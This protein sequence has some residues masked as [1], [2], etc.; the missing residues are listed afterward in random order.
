VVTA[1]SELEGIIDRPTWRYAFLQHGV[2]KDDLS[3]WLNKKQADLF[4]V[5][6]D[7]ELESVAGD[8]TAYWYTRKETRN[9]G[10]PRFDRL[11]RKAAA[12]QPDARDIVLVAPTWRAWLTTNIDV[13][14]FERDIDSAFWDSDYRRN[15]DRVLR[16]PRIEAALA[17]AGLTLG[18]MPHPAMQPILGRLD[19]PPHVRPFTFVGEDVQAL[20]AR[21]ALLVTDYSSVAFNVAYIDGPIVYFQFDR[22]AMQQGQHLG[23]AG[24]FSYERDGFGPVTTTADQ[25]IDAIV[26]Q[27][28]RGRRPAPEYQAR[29]AA[30]FTHRDGRACERV[31][32]AIE[33]M[34][35]PYPWPADVQA[36]LDL[37]PRSKA[38]A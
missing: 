26:E 10:L 1:P 15:W 4:V 18:F 8:G 35:R 9:T 31:V 19:L 29:I 24:Y 5:S 21:C 23:R 2:I 13:E 12:V 16:S 34:G 6:T 7:A 30:T 38:G 36:R 33:E 37:R 17:S 27:I 28:E 25:A 3:S 14:T 32:A 11:L 22:D 20:Y